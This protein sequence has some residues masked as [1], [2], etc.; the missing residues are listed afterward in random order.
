MP[1]EFS[2]ETVFAAPSVR[3][4][5][6]AYYEPDHLAAQDVVGQL[7]DRTVVE[8]IDNDAMRKC[9]WNVRSLRPLPMFVRPFIEGG[10]LRY[11]E[12]MTWR[13]AADEI[14]LN[15]APQI[16]GGRVAINATYKLTLVGDGQVKRRYK[17]AI[18]ANI[19]LLAGKIERGIL[20]EIEK[21]MPSMTEC[22]Q[23]W[24]S[25]NRGTP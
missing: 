1:T 18:S 5:L 14:D 9:T 3:T 24:L 13:K 6:E 20:S 10:H 8:N 22:T 15:I 4:I 19:A 23:A 25:R 12:T 11:L 17:G 21:G 7:G 16:L 2:F